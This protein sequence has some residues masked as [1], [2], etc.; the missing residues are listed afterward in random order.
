MWQFAGERHRVPLLAPRQLAHIDA[1]SE[2]KPLPCFAT[3]PM[4]GKGKGEPVSMELG[5]LPTLP[6]R[7][8]GGGVAHA[9]SRLRSLDMRS[10]A[11]AGGPESVSRSR[12]FSP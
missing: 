4:P 10:R 1:G 8:I 11:A 7:L 9:V 5:H 2:P 6:R 12:R 3:V